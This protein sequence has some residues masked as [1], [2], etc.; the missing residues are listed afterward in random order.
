[1]RK[2]KLLLS[3]SVVVLFSFLFLFINNG[4]IV[5]VSLSLELA[6]RYKTCKKNICLISNKFNKV[7][8][9]N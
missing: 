3:M 4:C 5:N 6:H 7:V 1:M 9:L 2:K 8:P